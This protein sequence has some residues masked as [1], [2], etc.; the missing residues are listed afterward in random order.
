MHA[1]LLTGLTLR[2][3][4]LP[5]AS[6]KGP[7]EKFQTWDACETIIAFGESLDEAQKKFAAWLRRPP[8]DGSPVGVEIKK[9]ASAQFVNELFTESGPGPL[10]WPTI[11]KQ[12]EVLL[13]ATPV[14]DFEQGY[15]VDVEQ[16]VPREPLSA[17]IEELQRGLPEDIS[18]G[19]NWSSDKQFIFVLS[20]LTPP[21]LP[22]GFG[23]EP[24]IIAAEDDDL[25]DQRAEESPAELHA[26]VETYP[27]ARRQTSR[28]ADS[29]PQ[30]GGRRVAL[31]TVCRRA[32]TRCAAHSHRSVVRRSGIAA[33]QSEFS[34]RL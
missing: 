2:T 18:T 27:Q 13:E 26:L 15:W 22:P 6:G 4:F 24:E 10:D 19:L 9:I 7:A 21:P 17:G 25:P 16:V 31:A 8:E 12:M 1:Y 34:R 32:A 23:G 3:Q 33:S 11:L 29:S 14:D 20:L 28:G 5:N 30:F